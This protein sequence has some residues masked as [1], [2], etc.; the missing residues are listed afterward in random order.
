MDLRAVAAS[1]N[2]WPGWDDRVAAHREQRARQV[3]LYADTEIGVLAPLYV[4]VVGDVYPYLRFPTQ[5]KG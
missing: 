2:R 3:I 5:R 1:M 4:H